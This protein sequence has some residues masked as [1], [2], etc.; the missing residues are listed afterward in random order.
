MRGQSMLIAAF[1]FA[2]IIAVFAVINVEQVQVNFLFAKTSTP[3]IL[4]IL[5]STF[6]GGL[7]AGSF[8]LV[9]E[10]KLRRTVKQLEKQIAELTSAEGVS[11]ES[12]RRI[13]LSLT[14]S[15]TSEEPIASFGEESR[16]AH[17]D[18]AATKDISKDEGKSDK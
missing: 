9:R 14:Q 10:F 8:G 1:A 4:V 11:E 7:S 13:A 18:D 5:A 6:L 17:A 12:K 3:L 2:L 16:F 15:D